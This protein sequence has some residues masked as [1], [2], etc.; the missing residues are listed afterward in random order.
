MS[1]ADFDFEFQMEK[2]LTRANEER[3]GKRFHSIDAIMMLHGLM[4]SLIPINVIIAS[5]TAK[6]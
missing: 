4:V 3:F 2:A 1:S 6:V 5:F